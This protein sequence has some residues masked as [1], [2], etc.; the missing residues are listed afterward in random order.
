MREALRSSK[1]LGNF[2][3][4]FYYSPHGKGDG[5]KLIPI[6]EVAAKDEFWNV[7]NVTRDDVLSAHRTPPQLL[8][9]IPANAGGFGSIA[10][11]RM[12]FFE[13]EVMPLQPVFLDLNEWA[14]EEVVR[15][16]EVIKPAA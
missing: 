4:L 5:V 10:D 8:G 2:K 12:V 9:I 6:S 13:S 1:G 3:N 14:G 11:A 7:K 16:R 15:F